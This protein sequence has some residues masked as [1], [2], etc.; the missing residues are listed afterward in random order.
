MAETGVISADERERMA[1]DIRTKVTDY[2]LTYVWVIRQIAKRGVH[3]NRSEMSAVLAGSRT[4]YKADNI[5]MNSL[6]VLNKYGAKMS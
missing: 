4:G 2:G 1:D 3:T 5:L 6:A